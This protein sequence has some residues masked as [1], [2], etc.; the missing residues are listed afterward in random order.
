M[1][2]DEHAGEEKLPASKK[3]GKGEEK[4]QTVIVDYGGGIIVHQK[5][6]DGTLDEGHEFSDAELVPDG[7]IPDADAPR[8]KTVDIDTLIA[9]KDVIEADKNQNRVQARL[10]GSSH[11]TSLNLN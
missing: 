6:F 11:F 4:P 8:I 7:A 3:C 1:A 5:Q 2:D 9:I 10:L